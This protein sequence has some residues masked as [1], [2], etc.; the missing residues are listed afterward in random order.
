FRSVSSLLLLKCDEAH[1]ANEH[2]AKEYEPRKR[3]LRR[4]LFNGLMH[5]IKEEIDKNS[6]RDACEKTLP[7][8]IRHCNSEDGGSDPDIDRDDSRYAP[9]PDQMPHIL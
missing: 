4:R 8:P 6:G 1:E 5:Q 7:G 9:E 3:V 2:T